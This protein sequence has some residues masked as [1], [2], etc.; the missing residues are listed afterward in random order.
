MELRIYNKK[1][2]PMGVVDEIIT[3]IWQI[4]YFDVGVC[5][6]LAPATEVNIK[7]IVKGNIVTKH[8]TIPDYTDDEGN[9]WRRAFEISYVK[10]TKNNKGQEQI[11]AQGF[12]ISRWLSKRV[13]MQQ[14]VKIGT[15]QEVINSLIDKNCGELAP[16]TRRF[17]QFE[18]IRQKNYGGTSTKYSNEPYVDLG[19][20]VKTVAQSG[21][22]G[23]DI[24]INEK[25]K[26]YGFYLYKGRD[27]TSGNNDGNDPCI[28]AREFDNV[29][30]QEYES[31]CENL[32]NFIVI[33]GKAGEAE[34][35][36]PVVM[37]GSGLE[38]GLELQEVFYKSDIER[39]Y[40]ND[41][42]TQEE[43][44]IDV[45]KEQLYTKADDELSGYEETINFSSDINLKSSMKYKSDYDVGDRVT[46]LEHRWGIVLNARITEI[47]ETYQQGKET[48]EATFGQSEPSLLEKIRKV[49]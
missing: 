15:R 33:Q 25:T 39:K 42:G 17:P 21:K 7:K 8:N 9:E 16:E 29:E 47:T 31:C 4:R 28:F 22:L 38:S 1:L 30:E 35:E 34:T 5:K 45:Y 36:A 19:L 12:M 6:L 14:I 37:K 23:Y 10:I 3:L 18:K 20:E 27:L 41:E 49:R 43:I 44:P 2:E 24:L 11:E 46:C 40:T 13:V 48:L 26:R 32:K